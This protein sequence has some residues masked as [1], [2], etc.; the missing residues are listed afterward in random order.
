MIK[1]KKLIE[2]EI[3]RAELSLATRDISDTIQGVIEKISDI[4]IQDLPV[5]V[6]QIKGEYGI[7]YGEIYNNTISEL[8]QGNL[9]T[10][11]QAKSSIDNEALKLT[12]DAPL[13]TLDNTETSEE[14][15]PAEGSA[16]G[17]TEEPMGRLKK[18]N[19]NKKD[20]SII[21]ETKSG[22]L[23]NKNFKSVLEAENF[24]TKNENVIKGLK[25]L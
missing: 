5:I 13:K 18:E 14:N 19:I 1:V 2:S 9:E 3:A 8:L 4:A 7:E 16:S 11:K 12:G 24:I 10:L 15:I 22:V 21:F 23:I 17:P 25:V 20:I 6:S